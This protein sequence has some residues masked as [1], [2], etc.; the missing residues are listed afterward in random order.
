[1]S[2]KMVR[3]CKRRRKKND[4]SLKLGH[5]SH[6]GRSCKRVR[7][8]SVVITSPNQTQTQKKTSYECRLCGR[9]IH[10]DVDWESFL[11]PTHTR[12][13]EKLQNHCNEYHPTFPIAQTVI[14]IRG[15]K[16]IQS[17]DSLLHRALTHVLKLGLRWRWFTFLVD[18]RINEFDHL[19]EMTLSTI[20]NMQRHEH[21]KLIKGTNF[22]EYQ[23]QANEVL[24]YFR[25]HKEDILQ[26][27]I[28]IPLAQYEQSYIGNAFML[29]C[30]SQG[31]FLDYGFIQPN[32][33]LQ[34]WYKNKFN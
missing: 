9:P 20:M 26:R 15:G 31:G 16:E 7:E 3:K 2:V 22:G 11:R 8:D 28:Q 29:F 5:T 34:E 21:F 19:L 17:L 12:D 23:K 10:A 14:R 24:L 32:R 25:D 13:R 4:N 33:D 30:G 18:N 6:L 1:M 27:V